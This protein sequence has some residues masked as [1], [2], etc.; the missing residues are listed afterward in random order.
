MWL[1]SS[2]QTSEKERFYSVNIK[3][4]KMRTQSSLHKEFDTTKDPP[5]VTANEMFRAITVQLTPKFLK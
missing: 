4:Y 5:F 1:L 3:M 2:Y